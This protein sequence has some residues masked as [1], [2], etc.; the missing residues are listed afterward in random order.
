MSGFLD[1][2]KLKKIEKKD[3]QDEK[4][5]FKIHRQA[6]RDDENVNPNISDEYMSDEET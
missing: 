4:L 2:D 3:E 5:K 6:F 1:S